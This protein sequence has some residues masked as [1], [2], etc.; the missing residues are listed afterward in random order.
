VVA[1][2]VGPAHE[3]PQ[4]GVEGCRAAAA[5][6]ALPVPVLSVPGAGGDYGRL[7]RG[8]R[9]PRPGLAGR[10]A[11]QLD[12][13]GVQLGH[14]WAYPK[15]DFGTV[16]VTSY[17]PVEEGAVPPRRISQSQIRSQLRQAQAKAK[18]ELERE[19]EK[20]VK[21][22]ETAWN[23][24]ATKLVNDHN[25]KARANQRRLQ[26]A[27]ARLNNQP[28][29]VR[30]TVT[31]TSALHLH[32]LYRHVEHTADTAGWDEH[33]QRLVDLAEAE[34][35]NSALVANTLL[36]DTTDAEDLSESTSLTDELSTVSPDLHNRWQGALYAINGANP[37]AARH[38]CTSAREIIVKMINL[39]APNA[40]V[41]GTYPDGTTPDGKVARRWKIQYLLDRYGANHDSLGE[42]VEADVNDVM[43]L[44][45][46]F[47]KGTHGEAGQFDL[48]ELRVIKTRVEGA[49]R[50]LSAII[51]GI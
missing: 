27:I 43:N 37:D 32:T 51:R 44:F 2:A 34:A 25:R 1:G 45:S 8:V 41:L 46:D 10:V 21:K 31:R 19:L 7:A 17:P 24:E 18:R 14:T 28:T 29:T 22:V 40:A 26:S 20:Q 36:G 48:A 35:A 12:E 15:L 6:A 38:F 30:Y 50:F 39:K 11:V 23:R 4:M 47:N 13:R 3:Q 33:S 9:R 5:A 42:F 49:V 16:G